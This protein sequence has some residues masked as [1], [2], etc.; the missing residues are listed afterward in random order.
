MKKS[1]LPLLRVA[2]DRRH[3]ITENGDPFF[4]MG[5]TA[6]ELFHRLSRDEARGV[7]G[8]PGG[9]GLHDAAGGGARGA[10]RHH[11][12]KCP[13]PVAA[14]AERAGEMGSHPAGSGRGA[15]RLKLLGPCGSHPRHGGR[16]RPVH[17]SAA[18]LGRQVQPHVGRRA[19]DFHGAECRSLWGL[20]WQPLS[21]SDKPC[22]DS[23]RRPAAADTP[24]FQQYPC[25][26]PAA[27]AAA[28]RG[29]ISS[30][31]TQAAPAPPPNR[32]TTKTGSIST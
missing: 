14:Q 24:S 15:G 13:W 12:A 16:T 30:R 22:L 31:S 18:H 4:W 20:D 8:L 19:R 5:D 25:N 26:A 23:W 7:S 3:L 17:W 1:T 10:V 29:D 28:T 2:N 21:G 9:A 32:S 6:W 27:S 11:R